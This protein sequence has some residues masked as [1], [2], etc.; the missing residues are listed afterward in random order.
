MQKK[1]SWSDGGELTPLPTYTHN[2]RKKWA[3]KAPPIMDNE[4]HHNGNAHARLLWKQTKK[5]G[6]LE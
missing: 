4:E 2:Q 1:G 3:T 5:R 6:E